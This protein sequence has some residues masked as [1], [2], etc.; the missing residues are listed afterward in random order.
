[1]NCDRDRFVDKKCYRAAVISPI[2]FTMKA[3]PDA[4]LYADRYH[5]RN[6]TC[7]APG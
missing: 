2:Q 5:S 3:S 7:Q 1:M 4:E 6:V